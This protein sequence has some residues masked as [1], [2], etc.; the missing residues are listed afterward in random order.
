MH[1]RDIRILMDGGSFDNFIHPTLVTR[2]AIPLYKAPKFQLQVGSRKLLQCEEEVRD[3]PVKIQQ[4][5]LSINAF[6]LPI[7]SEELVLDD[8]WL[9]TLDTRLVNYK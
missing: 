2:L 3:I 8:I 7:A 4:H 6:V 9:E 5:I 1:G